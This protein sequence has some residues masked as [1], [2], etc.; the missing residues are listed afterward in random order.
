MDEELIVNF[1]TIES[2]ASAINN[3]SEVFTGKKDYSKDTL[4]KVTVNTNMQGSFEA[5]QALVEAMGFNMTVEVAN[6]HE[7]KQDFAD[8]DDQIATELEQG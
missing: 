2:D 7:L 4:S 1:E 6:I 8:L 5:S 3:E